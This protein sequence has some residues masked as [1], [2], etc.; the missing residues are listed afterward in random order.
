MAEGILCQFSKIP[1]Q[2]FEMS[3]NWTQRYIK[4]S[5]VFLQIN[6]ENRQCVQIKH[7]KG[8]FVFQ[9]LIKYGQAKTKYKRKVAMQK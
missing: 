7:Q 5:K 4:F 1:F 8:I 2:C 9:N 3:L 6:L